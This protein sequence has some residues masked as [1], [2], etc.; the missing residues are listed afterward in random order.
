MSKKFLFSTQKIK[1]GD[2]I[3]IFREGDQQAYLYAFKDGKDASFIMFVMATD[4]NG[5]AVA[6]YEKVWENSVTASTL[7][8]F[9]DKFTQ[10]A[11]FRKKWQTSGEEITAVLQKPDSLVHPRCAQAIDRINS[12]RTENLRFADF[13]NLK[14]FGQ[15]K[16]SRMKMDVLKDIVTK[17]EMDTIQSAV[18]ETEVVKVLRWVKR[19]LKLNHAIRKVKVDMEIAL[20]ALG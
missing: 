5:T 14:T 12:Q 13:A 20:N 1:V 18:D 11:K 19:G 6:R 16:V 2:Y 7:Q 10:D 4:L 9:A 3:F 17:D 15:D 8:N